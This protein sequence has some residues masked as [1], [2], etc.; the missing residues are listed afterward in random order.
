MAGVKFLPVAMSIAVSVLSAACSPPTPSTPPPAANKTAE[1]PLH[2]VGVYP[3]DFHCESLAPLATLEVLLGGPVH[4]LDSAL[5]PPSGVPSPCNYVVDGAADDAGVS[6]QA[7]TFDIDCRPDMQKRA[8]ALFAQ[9][10]SNSADLVEQYNGIS[11]AGLPP[12]HDAAPI[13]APTGASPVAVGARG[14]D[15]HGQ[16][17]LFIDDDAPCYVRVVGPSAERRLALAQHLAKT[18][19]PATAP[20]S[21]RAVR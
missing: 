19:T 4:V 20:M 18:L 14:L 13:H 7:W 2:L 1:P 11:D 8:D 16:G 6:Q 21:P 12:D 15:H 10:T 9:Y 5:Q 17:L 3:K